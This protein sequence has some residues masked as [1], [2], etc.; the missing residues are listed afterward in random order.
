MADPISGNP[1]IQAVGDVRI[2]DLDAITDENIN[3]SMNFG[4]DLPNETF[5]ATFQQ[6]VNYISDNVVNAQYLV[7]DIIETTND[8]NPASRGLSGTWEEL[9]SDISFLTVN[10]GDPRLGTITGENN[11]EIET[12]LHS[13]GAGTL[14]SQAHTHTGATHTHTI[15]HNH[16]A[17]T[18]TRVQS[19]TAQ[20]KY[21]VVSGT[22]TGQGQEHNGVYSGMQSGL[23]GGTRTANSGSAT[24]T[25]GSAGGLAVTGSTATTGTDGVTLDVT[26]RKLHVIKWIKTA[27]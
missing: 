9:D 17:G 26:G 21:G 8:S 11:P 27:L 13:H 6:L 14:A 22:V 20:L 3:L 18:A 16:D 23:T 4:V 24:G 2:N 12:P 7:G 5:K 1:S 10:T 19:S 15:S 25:T